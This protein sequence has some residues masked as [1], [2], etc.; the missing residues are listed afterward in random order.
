MFPGAPILTAQ[1]TARPGP[2]RALRGACGFP[3]RSWISARSAGCREPSAQALPPPRNPQ[4]V[5]RT[6]V[7]L[8]SCPADS[9]DNVFFLEPRRGRVRWIHPRRLEKDWRLRWSSVRPALPL[10]GARRGEKD[11]LRILERSLPRALPRGIPSFEGR[12]PTDLDYASRVMPDAERTSKFW[13]AI[14]C[15]RLQRFRALIDLDRI[16]HPGH[17]LGN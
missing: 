6:Y 16:G 3:R 14:A 11:V 9:G 10:P 15:K 12:K 2:P 7:A 13:E 1:P 4:I 5:P 8:V 17:G